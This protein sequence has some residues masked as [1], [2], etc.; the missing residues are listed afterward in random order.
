MKLLPADALE[1]LAN[2]H[3]LNVVPGT[4]TS[5]E[6]TATEV[7]V[8]STAS[9]KL[10]GFTPALWLTR[11]DRKDGHTIASDPYVYS[12][13]EETLQDA[14]GSDAAATPTPEQ[15]PEA[16]HTTHLRSNYGWQSACTCGWKSPTRLLKVDAKR[17][18]A[19]HVEDAA[20]G[21]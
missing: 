15:Q 7:E 8:R 2:A 17:F 6:V 13:R 14:Q 5:I 10:A 19:L 12:R 4:V 3:L 11:F 9:S 18:A 1:A 16:T 21:R 20:K